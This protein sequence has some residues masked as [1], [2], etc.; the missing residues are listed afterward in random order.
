MKLSRTPAPGF[1]DPVGM[2]RACHER[3]RARLATLERLPAHLVRHGVDRAAQ[4]AAQAVVAYFERAAPRHHADEEDDL[5]PALRACAGRPGW[6]PSLAGQLEALAAE[7]EVLEQG[8]ETLRLDLH[9]LAAGCAAA[10]EAPTVTA[11]LAAYR[12]HMEREE[13]EILPRVAA[14]LSASELARIGAAMEARRLPEPAQPALPPGVAARHVTA[15]YT[16]TD[17]P[18]ALR[19]GH[20]TEAGVW[21]CITVEQGRVRYRLR[22]GTRPEWMLAAG[23]AGPV[24]PGHPY[25][26]EPLGRARFRLTFYCAAN[27]G[28]DAAL[29]RALTT[30]APSEA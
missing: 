14:L 21:V 4:E 16:E 24:P 6:L 22:S 7:H 12:R 3:M 15:P 8:W 1:A 18:Q 2:L 5:F 29:N 27:G 23:D 9:A 10:L 25:V 28:C 26:V 13:T 30:L 17:L 20:V 11:W 19:L